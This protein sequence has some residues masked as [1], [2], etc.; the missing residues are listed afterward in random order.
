MKKSKK[1]DEDEVEVNNEIPLV[2]VYPFLGHVDLDEVPETK[3]LL[4]DPK[5]M[6]SLGIKGPMM[7]PAYPI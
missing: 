5:I 6:K 1:K 3:K 4:E 2:P 7:V